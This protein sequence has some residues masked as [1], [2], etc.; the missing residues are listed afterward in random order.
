LI[1]EVKGECGDNFSAGN[2]RKKELT[3]G[4]E[5]AVGNGICNKI[6]LADLQK[7][8]SEGMKMI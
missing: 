5:K 4:T 6:Y 1:I 3:Y 7:I 8:A 2:I